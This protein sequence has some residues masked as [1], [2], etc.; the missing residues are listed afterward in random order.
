MA[1]KSNIL[2]YFPSVYDDIRE[3]I[4]LA[5]IEDDIMDELYVEIERGINNTFVLLADLEGIE[6][7]ERLL[8][9]HA[10]PS[11]ET[12]EFRRERILNR[13]S[14]RAPLT[15]PWLRMRMDEFLGEGNYTMW[16]DYAERTLHLESPIISRDYYHECLVTIMTA[17]P[18]NCVFFNKPL[19]PQAMVIGEKIT[20]NPT[21][22][23]YILGEWHLANVPFYGQK[24][25]T[26]WN[27]G[28]NGI[29]KLGEKPFGYEP[30]EDP[31]KMEAFPSLTQD[32]LNQTAEFVRSRVVRVLLNNSI[33]ITTFTLN[34]RRNNFIHI[35]YEVNDSMT[36]EVQNIKLY[37]E[38]NVV[39]SEVD[40]RVPIVAT[41][42]FRHRIGV[43]DYSNLEQEAE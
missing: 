21:D 14:I 2:S 24:Y 27:Y 7:F 38:N 29:W 4:I 23:N 10:S 8:G 40:V 35:Q 15:M 28:L 32:L 6:A 18:A 42:Y 3:I 39:L 13:I 34:E 31:V 9:I 16:V 30:E 22:F 20:V 12:I 26:T 1:T 25:A 37:D 33:N 36:T 11:T 41:S 17:K 19:I 43:Y 5:G